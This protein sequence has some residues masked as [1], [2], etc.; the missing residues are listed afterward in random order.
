MV[1]VETLATHPD[2]Q[3]RGYATALLETVLFSA[4]KDYPVSFPPTTKVN[5]LQSQADIHGHSVYLH[6]SNPANIGF[7]GLFGFEDV[8]G[9]LLGSDNPSWKGPPIRFALVRVLSSIS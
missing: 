6:T 4:S 1:Y 7:Y 5:V 8:G 3:G 9:V 2:Y